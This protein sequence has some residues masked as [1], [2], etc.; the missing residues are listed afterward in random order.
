MKGNLRII[1][2]AVMAGSLPAQVPKPMP[3]PTPN[4]VPPALE[5]VGIDQRLNEQAPLDL[6]FTDE[7]G[8]SAPLRAY[9]RSKPVV[10]ALVYYECPM[11]CTEILNGMVGALKGIS[12]NAG[13][14]YDVVA[15]SID[16]KDTPETA[17]EKKRN[18]ARRY[19]R[20]G[21]EQAFHFL[22]GDDA[23]IRALTQAV[24]FRYKY[25]EK[26]G[27]FAHASAIFVLTPQ[28]RISRVLYGVEYA[29]RDLVEASQNKIGTPVDQ[30]LLFCY[31]YDPSTGRYSAL[32]LN[33][34]RMAGVAF[35]IL[36]S[37]TLLVF[38]RRD[39]RRARKG[40]LAAR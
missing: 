17:G 40:A 2:L 1:A 19:G 9:F 3:S 18:Y 32:V 6:V 33:I 11:L 37:A 14:E 24:G 30:L 10:L 28:G 26:S 4:V 7:S 29:P 27:Q 16:P 5:G 15:V 34:V 23:A 22:T 8:Q 25:D 31:H 20:Q 38:W 13:R 36:I 35:L 21:A 39:V 12:F